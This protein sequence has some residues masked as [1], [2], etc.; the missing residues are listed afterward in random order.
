MEKTDYEQSQRSKIASALQLAGTKKRGPTQSLHTVNIGKIV[1]QMPIT[2]TNLQFS[3]Q[4]AET[5]Q[6]I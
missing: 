6:S 3:S 2:K 4:C 5:V 1:Q